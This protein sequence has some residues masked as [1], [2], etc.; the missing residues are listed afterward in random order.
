MRGEEYGEAAL[1]AA[2]DQ[3]AILMVV[4]A[5]SVESA[6]EPR[7]HLPQDRLEEDG[8]EQHA[9]RHSFDR[10]ALRTGP[11]PSAKDQFSLALCRRL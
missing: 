4:L 6:G 10:A 7:F 1:P 5:D 8:I 3:D 11:I 9:T 2:A